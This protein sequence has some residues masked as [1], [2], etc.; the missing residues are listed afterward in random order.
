MKRLIAGA[1]ALALS[2]LLVGA[3]TSAGAQ[4][5]I[6]L[7]SFDC[8]RALDPGDRSAAVTAVMRPVTGTKHMAMRFDLLMS[9][10]DGSAPKVVSSGDLGVW[11][12]PKNPTL[13]QLPG[14]V[15][16]LQKSVVNLAAPATYRFRVTFRWIGAG[17]HTL[18]TAVRLSPRCQQRELR[19]DLAVES[20]AVTPAPN[21]PGADV[22]KAL[23]SNA[24][25]SAAGPFQVLFAPATGSGTKTRTVP[26]L[27]AHRSIT[28]RFV[29]PLCTA[30]DAPTV[31]ADS[32]MEVDDLNRANNSMT[33]VCP[34]SSGQV[35]RARSRR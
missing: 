5:R 1:V 26:K 10:I 25:N 23:I 29:G 32:T 16:K 30:A 33:A 35:A 27:R 20:I 11:I 28:E 12:T 31:T 13:G 18:G 2:A 14:D 9:S 22:Y 7:R 21:N 3:A 15:W 17:G 8:H 24:G 4:P 6:Q 34:A 19:P